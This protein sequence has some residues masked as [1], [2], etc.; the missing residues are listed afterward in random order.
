[1][2]APDELVGR[3]ALERLADAALELAGAEGI[4]VVVT[5]TAGGLTRFANSRIHQNVWRE[6]TSVS[7]RAVAEAGRAGVA[8]TVTD[9]PRDVAEVAGRA[10]EAARAVPPD[11]EF[12]GLAPAEAVPASD[13]DE[14]VVAASPADRAA[15]V[16]ALLAELPDDHEGAGAYETTATELLVATSAGQRAYSPSTA[17]ALTVVV[18][19]PTSSGWGESGGR[20]L[21]DV[22][23]VRAGRRALRKAIA[24]AEPGDVDAGS[25]PVVLE[26]AATCT[27]M[28]FLSYL[29]FGGR[30]YLEGRSVAAQRLGEQV[31]DPR[32]T[33]T[34]DALSSAATGLGFDWE[35]TPRRRVDLIR[36]GV[37]AGV[38]HDRRTG[39]LSGSGST[40]HA[41][42]A[43][44]A[45]GPIAINPVLAPGD[46]G[47]I[48]DLVAG[49]ERGL[50][51][52]RFH[53]TNVVH[54]LETT[55]TGM[56]RDGTFLVE[57]GEI[58]HGVRN[59]RFTES[60]LGALSSVDAISSET[61]YASEL[62]PGGSRWPGLRLPAFRFS[63]T[64]TF[65]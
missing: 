26:P 14:A 62:F 53:Y 15:G 6:D 23:P 61:E 60:I 35:G 42:P 37:L 43:P 1:M 56:T 10:L 27:L 49:L 41:L 45:F 18:M 3:A 13:W 36:D 39:A 30:A 63:G 34:D 29:A 17:A 2:A 32:I 40:G 20:R 22:D 38:V 44:N 25:Y 52:T 9:D 58:R 47:A 8:G 65:G 5:R 46:G 12:P 21:A 59:L 7:V 16:A 33:L 11:P 24:G 55:V 4:E 28:E 50:L 19:G 51:V 48:E 31:A 64:T 54:P 57:D